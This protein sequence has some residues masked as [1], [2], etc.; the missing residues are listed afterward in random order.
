[1]R[2]ALSALGSAG[3]V[4]PVV[5]I[6]S[7]LRMR[8]HDVRVVALEEYAPLVER[9][10]LHLEAV[11]GGASTLWPDI[12]WL[13]GLALA[14][15]GVMY[16]TMMTSFHSLAPHTNEALRR[17][18]D[19]VDVIVSGL[20]TR[21]AAAALAQATCADHLTVLFAP[22]LPASTTSST[23]L[24]LARG[25]RHVLRAT[26]SAMWGL[27]RGLSAA[28]TAD[29]TR[30]VGHRPE[31][32][33]TLLLATSPVVSPPARQWPDGV[34]QVGWI[35]S[36]HGP[37]ELPD[38]VREFLAGDG[39]TAVM[40][41][42]SCPVV[43]AQRDRRLFVEAARLA[44]VRLILTDGGAPV[45]GDDVLVT[46]PV[47]Y[48]A[49]LP[50]VSAVVHH[51]GAGTTYAA[52]ASGTPSVVVPHLGDQAYYARRVAELGAGPRGVPRWRVT[53]PILARRVLAALEMREGAQATAR[54]LGPGTGARRIADLVEE[55]GSQPRRRE[56]PTSQAARPASTPVQPSQ[57]ANGQRAAD[58]SPPASAS[59]ASS[60]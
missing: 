31:S 43:S 48:E 44:G 53:A 30:R 40:T 57:L 17:A 13:R 19:G 41:F 39:P 11:P 60:T 1:M 16:A 26:S 54:R 58:A 2:V 27:T 25:G 5:A 22:L 38:E 12:S 23:A 9:A 10:G 28:H 8:G 32:R 49:L 45:P 55:G 42:G 37:A 56:R 3:D 14:Q 6:G 15:P 52:L 35:P 18:A 7:T 59:R 29:M 33:S 21:G 24:G 51:G 34:E 47:S 46:G 36:V 20:V 50:Q 4:A